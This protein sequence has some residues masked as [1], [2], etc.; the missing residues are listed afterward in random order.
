MGETLA[1][2]DDIIKAFGGKGANMAVG[3]SRIADHQT[4]EVEMLGQVGND[5]EGETYLQYLK[6][7]RIGHQNV[8]KLDT[9]TG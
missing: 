9:V 2:H 4:T 5:T 8:S 7:N 3:C 6:D 1:A